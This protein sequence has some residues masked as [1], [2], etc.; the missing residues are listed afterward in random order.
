[1][2]LNDKVVKNQWRRTVH[3]VVDSVFDK[4]TMWSGG[5]NTSPEGFHIVRLIRR[6]LGSHLKLEE[7]SVIDA[8]VGR[9]I[10]SA[11]RI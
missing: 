3:E 1:M 8:I 4:Q 11:V 5:Q 2:V 9:G 7:R 6:V 10:Y